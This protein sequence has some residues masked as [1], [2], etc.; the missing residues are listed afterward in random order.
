MEAERAVFEILDDGC[1][2]PKE[3]MADIFT[4]YFEKKD[5]P[6]DHQKSSMGIG[7]SVCASIIKAH[8]GDISVE[9]R[10]TGGCCFRFTLDLEKTENE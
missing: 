3:R 5:A 7:L 4:G 8:E 6:A 9:N 2:I 10:K 1:G